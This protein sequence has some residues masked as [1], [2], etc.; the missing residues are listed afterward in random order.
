MS[1]PILVSGLG[2]HVP[3]IPPVLPSEDRFYHRW[4]QPRFPALEEEKKVFKK[5]APESRGVPKGGE[6]MLP[7]ERPGFPGGRSLGLLY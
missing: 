7:V 2:A 6:F 5:L 4:K 1:H 3:L